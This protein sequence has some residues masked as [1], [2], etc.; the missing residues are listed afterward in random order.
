MKSRISL[1]F[2]FLALIAL[3]AS[4]HSR[5][6]LTAIEDSSDSKTAWNTILT[7]GEG[8]R[9][10]SLQRHVN[11]SLRAQARGFSHDEIKAVSEWIEVSKSRSPR[12]HSSYYNNTAS[13][14]LAEVME[15][16]EMPQGIL[17]KAAFDDAHISGRSGYLSNLKCSTAATKART[18]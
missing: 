2:G 8:D 15:H 3:S 5:S 9:S 11:G 14:F 10:L 6:A 13:G 4:Q 12:A 7:C 18:E 17:I 16:P 1:L